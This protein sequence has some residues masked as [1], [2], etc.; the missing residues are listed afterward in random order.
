MPEKLLT[1]RTTTTQM[2]R[3]T[4]AAQTAKAKSRHAWAL[5][6]LDRAAA[7]NE[8][9]EDWLEERIRSVEESGRRISD[10]AGDPERNR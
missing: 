3:Y 10:E 5:A 2:S 1:L 9:G 8:P 6:V 7:K 4:R